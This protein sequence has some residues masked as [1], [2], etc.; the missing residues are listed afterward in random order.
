MSGEGVIASDDPQFPVAREAL[1]DVRILEFVF[2]TLTLGLVNQADAELLKA[3]LRRVVKD[4]SLLNNGDE[5]S[6]GRDTQ[7]EL[8]VVAVCAKGGLQPILVEPDIQCT[9]G[10]DVFSIAV[11]RTKSIDNFEKH[12]RKAAKQIEQSRKPGV[13]VMDVSLAVNRDNQP[14]LQPV[15][16]EDF[17]MAHKKATKAIFDDYF[18]RFKDWIGGREVRGVVLVQH[19]LRQTLQDGWGCDTC[20]SFASLSP[21]NQRR[22]RQFEAFRKGFE[23]GFPTDSDGRPK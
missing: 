6:P 11:K 15:S 2:D 12:V 22:H 14:I 5:N 18:R 17:A 20:W 21:D 3:M 23:A 7:C 4:A 13:L 10:N 9:V 16:D 19:W 1:R 8:H